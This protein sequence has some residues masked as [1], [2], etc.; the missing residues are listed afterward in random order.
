MI[1]KLLI[2]LSK[3][4]SYVLSHR[5]LRLIRYERKLIHSRT[6]REQLLVNITDIQLI[7][8]FC[9]IGYSKRQGR[10]SLHREYILIVDHIRQIQL[11]YFSGPFDQPLARGQSL[12]VLL[13]ESPVEEKIAGC[14]LRVVLILEILQNSV[15]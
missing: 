14:V 9:Q 2:L 5:R 15:D 11:H 12:H 4:L 7:L 1:C 10:V 13:T 6:H 3:P 8:H